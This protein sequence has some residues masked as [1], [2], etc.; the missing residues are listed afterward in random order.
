MEFCRFFLAYGIIKYME[1]SYNSGQGYPGMRPGGTYS[2][3]GMGSGGAF[4]GPNTPSPAP[5]PMSQ[6]PRKSRKGLIIGLILAVVVIVVA[7]VAVVVLS[8]QKSKE[9]SVFKNTDDYVLYGTGFPPAN[10]KKPSDFTNSN[11]GGGTNDTNSN[12]DGGTVYIM[13]VD[14]IKV[15]GDYIYAIEIVSDTSDYVSNVY[16]DVLREKMAGLD[17]NSSEAMRNYI[18]D[19]KILVNA[20]N[21]SE[22]LE[23]YLAAYNTGGKNAA[24]E[25]FEKNINCSTST[26]LGRIC[27]SEVVYYQTNLEKHKVFADA[28][29]LS[30][31]VWDYDCARKYY[32]E[33]SLNEKIN[34]IYDISTNE[35]FLASSEAKEKLN[36]EILKA[37]QAVRSEMGIR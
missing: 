4:S 8:N 32:G 7:V 21:R 13:D 15:E 9:N 6:A 17:G 2:G 35:R 20:M 11:T 31:S 26:E 23:K 27:N 28:K 12:D 14:N 37:S 22:V 3:A 30:A 29:C 34:A 18:D 1:P 24:K 10:T 25:Y 19:L 5:L 16:Y 36:E 33:E